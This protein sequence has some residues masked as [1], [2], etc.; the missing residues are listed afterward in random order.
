MIAD[1]VI[2]CFRTAESLNTSTTYAAIRNYGGGGYV[3]RLTGFMDSLNDSIQSLK[4]DPWYE[5]N[6][7]PLTTTVSLS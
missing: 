1:K 4:A 6:Q 3:L 5:F 2:S 7:L